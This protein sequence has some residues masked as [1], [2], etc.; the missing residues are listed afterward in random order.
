MDNI[1]EGPMQTCSKIDILLQISNLSSYKE[2]VI[3]MGHASSET[4]LL[5]IIAAGVARMQTLKLGKKKQRKFNSLKLMLKVMHLV[6]GT[7]LA[8]HRITSLQATSSCK[9]T[10][11][12]QRLAIE[13]LR[14]V[15]EEEQNMTLLESEGEEHEDLFC[16][17]VE[18]TK[19]S[20]PTYQ[21]M[22]G[23]ENIVFTSHEI[24]ESNNASTIDQED[25]YHP[26]KYHNFDEDQN[27]MNGDE[28]Q[29]GMQGD[30]DLG[31]C[32]LSFGNTEG[33]DVL[34]ESSYSLYNTIIK[35]MSNYVY[36]CF[37]TTKI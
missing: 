30:E 29:S 31:G 6:V 28:D 16:A 3:K 27:I 19:M 13:I 22:M 18:E 14:E 12:I 24:E 33:E 1:E 15:I 4:P 32:K 26:L 37:S 10:M 2:K 7:P 21:D 36:S 5:Q 17:L 9:K 11:Q 35:W 25:M 20:H 34:L 23:P 8:V